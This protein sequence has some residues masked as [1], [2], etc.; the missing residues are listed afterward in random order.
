MPS[1]QTSP[2]PGPAAEP[3]LDH[4]SPA[5][6]RTALTFT[7]LA[8]LVLVGGWI[9][10]LFIYDPGLMIDELPDQTFPAAAEQ[11]CASAKAEFAEL[12]LANEAASADDRADTV[13]ASNV[14]FAAMLADLEPHVTDAQ[15][16]Y[17]TDTDDR[18]TKQ[19]SEGYARGVGDWVT[20][21]GTYLEDRQEYVVALRADDDAR[22][23]E[24]AKGSDTK[25]I[26]RAINSFA[27]V[28]KMESCVTPGDLS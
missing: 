8:V 1:T 6:R 28:N 16:M 19:E 14:I 9:F 3:E 11:I 5:R 10:I 7:L 4:S 17:L 26:T 21:W 24:T 2:S 13:E 25:G 27:Q 12:P 18:F 15:D 20:D 23:L 22:F